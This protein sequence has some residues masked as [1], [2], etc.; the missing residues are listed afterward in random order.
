M[1]RTNSLSSKLSALG[2]MALLAGGLVALSGCGGD[3]NDPQVLTGSSQTVFGAQAMSWAQLSDDGQVE[4][5]G[6]TLPLASIQNASGEQMAPVALLDLPQQVK[7]QTFLNHI[8]LNW[9]EHGH[10]PMGVYTAPHFDIH[11]NHLPRPQVEAID[12]TDTTAPAANRLPPGYALPP[13]TA[14]GSC[15]PRM[16]YHASPGSNF[17]PGYTFIRT[18]ILGYY[19]GELRFVEP[20]ITRELLLQKQ[21]FTMEIPVP[22]VVG[23]STLYPTRF[24]AEW[25]EQEQAYRF[26]LSHFVS[27][28]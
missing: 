26:I 6:F 5:V 22:Q 9:N 21:T 10:P 27:V 8:E 23:V 17:A 7:T 16:G 11:F 2:M 13:T 19:G 28:S 25:N 12:C 15:V 18:M 1:K 3:D 14:P 24:T 4:Q 20:M